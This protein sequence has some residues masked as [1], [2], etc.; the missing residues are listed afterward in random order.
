MAARR[1]TWLIGGAG[2]LVCGVLGVL[3]GSLSGVGALG[4]VIGVATDSAWATAVLV[5]AFGFTKESSVVG[6]GWLGLFAMVVA[7]VWPLAISVTSE[8]RQASLPPDDVAMAWGYVLDVIPIG[9]AF[10]ACVQIIR[11]KRIPARWRWA[12]LVAVVAQG[13]VWLASQALLAIATVTSTPIEVQQLA[14]VVRNLNLLGFLLATFGLGLLAT[15]GSARASVGSRL[16][17]SE[18]GLRG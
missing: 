13:L 17:S 11:S 15:I 8:L 14:D 7:A 1:K 12:P 4:A 5:F 2:L 10:V 6:R 18:S 9:A 16:R 3:H